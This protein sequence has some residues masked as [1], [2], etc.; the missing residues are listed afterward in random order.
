MTIYPIANYRKLTSISK[1]IVVSSSYLVVIE[2]PKGKRGRWEYLS[3]LYILRVSF[4]KPYRKEL[5]KGL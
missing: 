1:E 5:G 2:E 3:K 4:S